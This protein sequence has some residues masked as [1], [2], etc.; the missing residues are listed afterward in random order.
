MDDD[1]ED[2]AG[3]EQRIVMALDSG[4]WRGEANSRSQFTAASAARQETQSGD[5]SRLMNEPP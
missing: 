3:H 1:D 5:V 4:D 2:G